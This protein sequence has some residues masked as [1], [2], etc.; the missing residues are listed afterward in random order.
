MFRILAGFREIRI[1][2][3]Q[4]RILIPMSKLLL[5]PDVPRDLVI[6]RFGRTFRSILVHAIL[7]HESTSTYE[8][9]AVKITGRS[10]P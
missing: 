1:G 4:H 10:R 2:T 9:G 5:H 6:F 7:S 3:L 8:W